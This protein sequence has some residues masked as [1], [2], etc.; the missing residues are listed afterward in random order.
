[1]ILEKLIDE[2]GSSKSLSGVLAD[3]LE[4]IMGKKRDDDIRV[5]SY[6]VRS[7]WRRR[8][9]PKVKHLADARRKRAL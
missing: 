7:H 8:W 1:M 4:P 3:L 5:R 2:G 9:H 6:I